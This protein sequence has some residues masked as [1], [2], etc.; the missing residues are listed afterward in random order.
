M[1]WVRGSTHVGDEEQPG[2]EPAQPVAAV[3]EV[4]AAAQHP[5]AAVV[6]GVHHA[7]RA[8]RW[9]PAAGR[10]GPSA[11]SRARL[12]S[13]PPDSGAPSALVR[14]ITRSCSLQRLPVP[15]LDRH[16]D[17]ARHQVGAAG[18]PAP[19]AG[20]RR[21]APRRAAS[22]AVGSSA[23]RFIVPSLKPNRLRGGRLAGRGRRRPAEARAGTSGC[24]ARP[25]AI[26][27]RLR[28]ACTATCGSSAQAWTHRS[29]SERVRVEVVAGEVRQP[30]QRG[31]LPAAS[32]KRSLPSVPEQRRARSRR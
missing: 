23:L 6:V 7:G 3:D 19:P 15:D 11:R 28:M 9:R 17:P 26:R 21:P 22:S 2:V 25:K 14:P 31:R 4:V 16:V 1:K 18:Q 32:P 27:A 8:R 13:V 10:R 5:D 30:A 24:A 29:P 20:P 12:N